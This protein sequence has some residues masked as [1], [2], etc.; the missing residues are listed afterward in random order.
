MMVQQNFFF[1]GSYFKQIYGFFEQPLKSCTS[2]IFRE[3]IAA[4]FFW[5]TETAIYRPLWFC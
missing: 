2:E 3:E 1:L 4:V 5:K